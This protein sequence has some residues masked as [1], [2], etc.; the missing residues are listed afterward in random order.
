MSFFV[1]LRFSIASGP[2]GIFQSKIVNATDAHD[3]STADSLLCLLLDLFGEVLQH[4]T[5]AATCFAKPR[6]SSAFLA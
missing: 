1:I 4:T 2:L 5:T 6:V 3:V